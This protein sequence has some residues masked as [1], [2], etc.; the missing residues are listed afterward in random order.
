[1]REKGRNKSS[2]KA[3][4][5]SSRGSGVRGERDRSSSNAAK[6]SKCRYG[7]SQGDPEK[8]GC[9]CVCG[10]VCVGV[11]GCG[12]VWV[13]VSDCSLSL[14]CQLEILAKRVLLTKFEPR[15]YVFL[16]YSVICN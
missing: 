6:H 11:C 13:G 16:E 8:G 3:T 10:C 2:G 15:C 5:P 14:H 4:D 12:C 1:M 7:S 9:V